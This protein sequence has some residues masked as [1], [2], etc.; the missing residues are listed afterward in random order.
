MTSAPLN[1]L[2]LAPLLILIADAA[3]ILLSA[4]SELYRSGKAKQRLSAWIA[5]T[6][7]AAAPALK[8]MVILSGQGGD[9][10][11]TLIG[12]GAGMLWTLFFCAVGLAVIAFSLEGPLPDSGDHHALILLAISGALIV[13]QAIHILALA[14]GLA[15]FYTALCALSKPFVVWQRAVAHGIG[16]ACL[17]LGIALLYGTTGSLHIPAVAEQLSKPVG[18]SN[19]L[20]TLGVALVVGGA[21]VPPANWLFIPAN[22]KTTLP[23]EIL[24]WL[25]LPGTT[26]AALSRLIQAQTKNISLLLEILGILLA[27][28]GYFAAFR[29]QPFKKALM[30]LAIAC[31]GT[32][33]LSLGMPSV[34]QGML[35]YLLISQAL[36]LVCLWTLPINDLAGLGQAHPQLVVAVT[37][38]LLNLA[39]MPPLAGAAAQLGLIKA[40]AENG[41]GWMAVPIIAWNLC[42]WLWAGRWLATMWFHSSSGRDLEYP[43]LANALIAWTVAGGALLA[44]LY[45]EPIWQWMANLVSST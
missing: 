22:D 14:L 18:T 27:I 12:D 30:G 29:V 35:W 3:G 39:G 23:G 31:L 26:I 45:A 17:F 38:C 6:G 15:I 11:G 28:S 37:L 21:L 24:T 2:I 13:A 40:A 10:Q 16:L 44:G 5:M 36:S 8:L 43:A 19:S 4:G 7:L 34:G 32:L 42:A 41:Q 20:S 1:L 25:T 33:I 9:V